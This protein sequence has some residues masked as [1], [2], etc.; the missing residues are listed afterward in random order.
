ML[1]AKGYAVSFKLVG[2]R[3]VRAG[4]GS[5]LLNDESGKAWPKCSGLVM[6]FTKRNEPLKD[7]NAEA[8]LM[9]DPRKGEI[10]TPPRALSK[11]KYVGEVAVVNY[12]R[13]EGPH[14]GPYYHPIDGAEEG[15]AKALLYRRG[16]AYRLELA[17][18]CVWNWR[19]IVRP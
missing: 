19:G 16:S 11:W 14:A 1:I 10:D 3:I 15:A 5:A 4:R 7:S 6:R 18:G 13:P 17:D 2:G 8:Y 9:V 12:T